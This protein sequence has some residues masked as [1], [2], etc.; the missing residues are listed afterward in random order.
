MSDAPVSA[1]LEIEDDLGVEMIAEGSDVSDL[2]KYGIEVYAYQ[3]AL[4]KTRVD[5]MAAEIAQRQE[6]IKLLHEILQ[7]INKLSDE[8]GLDLS[9]HPEVLKKLKIAKDLGIDVADD[10]LKYTTQERDFLKESL[11]MGAEDFNNDNKLQTQKMHMQIQE[12]D[13]WLM[14]ANTMVKTD[15]RIKRRIAE[16]LR[17]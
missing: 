3:A 15:E 11:Q 7:A 2:S 12:A 16:K 6:R 8:A 5:K 14:L 4:I 1:G 10:Q 13:R 9:A 17:S